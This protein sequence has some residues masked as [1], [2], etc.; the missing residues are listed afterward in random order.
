MNND[1]IQIEFLISKPKHFLNFTNKNKPESS[2]VVEF[3]LLKFIEIEGKYFTNVAS[4]IYIKIYIYNLCRQLN[5]YTWQLF[6]KKIKYS[7]MLKILK[8]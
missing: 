5:S 6:K 2:V 1:S 3:L 8:E 4:F 7:Y